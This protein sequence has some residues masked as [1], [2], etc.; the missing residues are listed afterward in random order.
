[1]LPAGHIPPNPAELLAGPTFEQVLAS[2]R[3]RFDFV[4]IDGPPMLGLADAALLA[5]AV[6]ATVFII[7]WGR[8]RTSQVRNAVDRLAAVEAPIVGAVLTKFDQTRAGYGYGYG[9]DY[10]YGT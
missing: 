1:L 3:Q 4:V 6:E 2:A 5:R 7:E 8:T 10:Q 9:Y